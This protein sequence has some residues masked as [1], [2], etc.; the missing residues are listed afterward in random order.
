MLFFF[1]IIQ[2]LERIE[3][4]F[5]GG[6]FI[7]VLLMMDGSEWRDVMHICLW[8]DTKMLSFPPLPLLAFF[9]FHKPIFLI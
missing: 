7:S 6:Y 2:T 8:A 9:Y 1:E 4:D 5:F 3:K